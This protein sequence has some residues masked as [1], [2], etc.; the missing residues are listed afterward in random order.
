MKF[1]LFALILFTLTALNATPSQAEPPQV[2]A[3]IKP[4]HGLVAAVM[5]GV[6]VPDLLIEGATSPH[7]LT[8]R[9]S[10]ARKLETADVLVWVGPGLETA[11]AGKLPVLAP[12]AHMVELMAAPGINLLAADDDHADEDHAS[13]PDHGAYDPHIWLA[14][15]NARAIV[16][17]VADALS[18][19]DPANAPRY[20]ANAKALDQRLQ[21]LAGD[22]RARLA[23]V[24]DVPF[25]VYHDA[26]GYMEQAFGL[27]SV[28][29]VVIA[30][31]R[32]AGTA[33][34]RALRNT[35]RDHRVR[36]LFT[37]PQFAPGLAHTVVEGL[38][39]RIATLDPLGAD[40]PQGPDLYDRLMERNARSLL[41]CLGTPVEG[42]G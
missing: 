10:D 23:P 12:R 38:A 18:T 16:R 6:G 11:L 15:D 1:P 19:R 40:L 14:P 35:L 42:P 31:E 36:C 20:T 37:E 9:P 26:F 5:D 33:H 39:I 3:T 22:I 21:K 4:I 34:V 29:H 25:A 8:L 41:D 24:S 17:A 27:S 30:P 28:G 2:V 32:M 7:T 13:D